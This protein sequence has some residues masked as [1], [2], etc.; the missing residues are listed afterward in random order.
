[1]EIKGGRANTIREPIVKKESSLPGGATEREPAVNKQITSAKKR[2][3]W[4]F[5]HPLDW[6]RPVATLYVTGWC[7]SRQGK[8]ICDIRARIGRLTFPGNYGIRRK[9]V[10]DALG[11]SSAGRIGFAIAV[12]LPAG[13]SQIVTEIQEADHVWRPIA[14]RDVVGA[15][16]GE[17][18]AP[19]DPKYFIPNPGANPRFEFWIDQPSVW[20]RKT[21]YLRVSGWCVAISGEEVTQVRARVRHKILRARFGSVRPDIGLLFDNRSGALRSGFSLDAIIP[22]GRS[23]F[24]IEARSGEGPWETFFIHPVRGPI[25]G[26]QF[27]EK[28]EMVGDYA[29]WVRRYDRLRGDD[30]RHIRKQIAQ[31]RDSPLISVLLPVYNSNLKWLRRA[32]RSVESQLYPRWELCIVDDA[33]TD[34]KVWQFLQKYARRDPRIKVMRRTQNGHISAASNDALGMAKGDFVALL[35][36]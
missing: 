29:L 35:D 1:M 32:I 19:I 10:V 4:W 15:S 7:L 14:I 16:D 28:Q 20:S 3:S 36:H 11:V 33:S 9:D 18:A 6:G 21:R 12:P 2:Y 13:K 23:Q 24:I 5:S 27:D 8:E 26:E 34:P 17:S 25:F 22:P 31:F 30:V